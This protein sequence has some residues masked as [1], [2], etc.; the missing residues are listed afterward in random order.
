MSVWTS[1]DLTSIAAIFL[2]GLGSV[3]VADQTFS[4]TASEFSA[5]DRATVEA[6]R[7]DDSEGLDPTSRSVAFYASSLGE[8]W[9]VTGDYGGRLRFD[10]GALTLRIEDVRI[11]F[12]EIGPSG[13]GAEMGPDPD[14]R[15]V[16][17]RLALAEHDE[18]GWTVVREGPAYELD[19]PVTRAD[20]LLVKQAELTL[21]GVTEEDML[22]RWLV[23]VHDLSTA[24]PDGETRATTYVHAD[25]AIL[26]RLMGWLEEGC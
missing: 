19:V 5:S 15:L 24:G 18:V 7:A 23:I 21:P 22:G 3:V 13:Q 25:E 26:H 9:A 20:E 4:R 17:V 6:P 16:G 2:G 11:A 10:E 12:N 14:A 1:G 8:Y